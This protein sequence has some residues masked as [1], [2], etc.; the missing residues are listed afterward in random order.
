MDGGTEARGIRKNPALEAAELRS[1]Q[2]KTAA[3]SPVL[4]DALSKLEKKAAI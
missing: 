3:S 2:R 4:M 1:V